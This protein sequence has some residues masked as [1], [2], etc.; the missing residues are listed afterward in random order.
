M[1]AED[2]LPPL[3]VPDNVRRALVDFIR[4]SRE[5]LGDGLISAVLYGSAAEGRMRPTSD[6]NVILV[7]RKFDPAAAERLNGPARMAE[8][9]V[10]LHAM[11]LLETELSDAAAAFALKFTDLASRHIVLFGQD[12]F[13]GL[14]VGR[15]AKIFRLRQVLLNTMLRM[16]EAMVIHCH[17]EERLTRLVAE[18]AGPL[19]SAAVALLDLE[20]APP[21]VNPKAALEQAAAEID[22][23]AF[24]DALAALTEARTECQLPP[25]TAKSVLMQLIELG[26]RLHERANRL[27][28]AAAVSTPKA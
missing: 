12:V 13:S 4:A 6:V 26:T 17:A 9:A 25:G 5:A 1:P 15:E 22:P 19:R 7:L 28:L 14:S 23:A 11:F 21:A 2:P 18:A 10:R 27:P 20:N 3:Q 16:R 24:T 8:A